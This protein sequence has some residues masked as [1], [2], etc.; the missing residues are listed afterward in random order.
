MYTLFSI[1]QSFKSRQKNLRMVV[2]LNTFYIDG[3]DLAAVQ[4]GSSLSR[5]DSTELHSSSS[6]PGIIFE[7]ECTAIPNIKK[8][9]KKK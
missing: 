3:W 6:D 9:R 8:I 4:S 5:S 2:L 7:V 1:S